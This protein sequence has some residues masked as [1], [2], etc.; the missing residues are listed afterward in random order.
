[1]CKNEREGGQK[2]KKK[3]KEKKRKE[4]KRRIDQRET[5]QIATPRQKSKNLLVEE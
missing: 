3:K 4:K 5:L 1:V 2:D